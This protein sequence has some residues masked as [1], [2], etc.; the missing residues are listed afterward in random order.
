MGFILPSV[1]KY[2]RVMKTIMVKLWRIYIN[3]DGNYVLCGKFL[4][5][6]S[7]SAFYHPLISFMMWAIKGM[8]PRIIIMALRRKYTKRVEKGV[9]KGN[10]VQV[11]REKK[12]L[13]K[14]P[15]SLKIGS[16]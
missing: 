13:C 8:F 6:P 10:V 4:F 16:R 14:K 7:L 9:W 11:T 15:V 2:G 5:R 12:K 1:M 3:M